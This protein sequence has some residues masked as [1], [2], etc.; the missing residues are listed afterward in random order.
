MISYFFEQL[1]SSPTPTVVIPG[2]VPDAYGQTTNTGSGEVIVVDTTQGISGSENTATHESV[3]AYGDV[4]GT[5]PSDTNS[6]EATAYGYSNAFSPGTNKAD[7]N[8]STFSSGN[9]FTPPPALL[10]AEDDTQ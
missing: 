2:K 7:P 4:T 6:S 5:A 9:P 8:S 3:H 1:E 10:P